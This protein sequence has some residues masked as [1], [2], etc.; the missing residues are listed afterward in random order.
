MKS[1]AVLRSEFNYYRRWYKNRLRDALFGSRQLARLERNFVFM[2]IPKAGGSS[3][4]KFFKQVFPARY[5]YP[6]PRLG[7]FPDYTSLSAKPPQLFMRHLGFRFA[8]EADAIKATLMRHPVERLLSL[9]SYTVNPGKTRPLSGGV[10]ARLSL[11]EFLNYDL[12]Q[13]HM[14]VNN[15]QCWQLGY[16]YSVP[17]RREFSR[18]VDDNILSVALVNLE[19]I[20]HLGV[21]EKFEQFQEQVFDCYGGQRSARV[22]RINVTTQRLQYSQL[23]VWEK[24]AVDACVNLDLQLY[25]ALLSRL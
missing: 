21:I 22:Q 19:Q 14:N 7:N 24:K 6:E 9:Y 11:L 20:E 3:T 12:P 4:R 15:A 25:E 17:E 8:S 2:H 16:G 10:P 13:V 23:S 1:R 5:M 18:R